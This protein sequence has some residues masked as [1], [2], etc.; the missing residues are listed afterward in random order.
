MA[1]T[2]ENSQKDNEVAFHGNNSMPEG[3]T[4]LFL[5]YHGNNYISGGRTGLILV[6]VVLYGACM[7]APSEAT[8]T[9]T[10]Y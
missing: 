9:H 10:G 3:G 7:V 5:V 2:S 8:C 6:Y 4:E 1:A